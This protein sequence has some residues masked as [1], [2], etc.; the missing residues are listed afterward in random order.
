MYSAIIGILYFGLSMI[1]EQR[2][3]DIP[4]FIHV[5]METDNIY[6][7]WKVGPRKLEDNTLSLMM[8]DNM[9][10]FLLDYYIL[11]QV[12][13]NN[14]IKGIIMDNIKPEYAILLHISGFGNLTENYTFNMIT[15]HK[16]YIFAHI[17]T[18]TNEYYYVQFVPDK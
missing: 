17:N 12:S 16:Y 15:Y 13:G 1:K 4:N 11:D 9:S 2:F 10:H 6:N 14:S 18:Y 8:M 7:S 5:E 3:S